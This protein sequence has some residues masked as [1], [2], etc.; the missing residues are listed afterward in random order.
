M[1]EP[2][3]RPELEEACRGRRPRSVSRQ[4]EELGGP[5]DKQRLAEWLGR[6]HQHQLLR[7]VR[8]IGE[9]P[10]EAVLDAVRD[11]NGAGQGKAT[12]QV[13]VR[14]RTWQLEQRERVAACLR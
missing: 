4:A 9:A 12:R 8:K 3:A 1:A 10:L 14:R 13:G 5:P 11:G 2:D 6:G 7:L